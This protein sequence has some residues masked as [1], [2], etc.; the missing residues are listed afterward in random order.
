M[1]SVRVVKSPD[2]GWRVQLE[3]NQRASFDYPTQVQAI[4]EARRL[5]KGE[6]S[7]LLIYSRSGQIRESYSYADDIR[8][9]RYR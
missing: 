9:K 2:G 4:V 3:G 7:R 1:Q 5:A 6:K 8:S